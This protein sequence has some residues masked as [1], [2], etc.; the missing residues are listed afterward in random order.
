MKMLS[1]DAGDAKNLNQISKEEALE[2]VAEGL[3][4]ICQTSR[5]DFHE[6]KE[7]SDLKQAIR[8]ADLG[9]YDTLKFYID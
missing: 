8:Y 3:A 5:R 6:V 9:V 4:I 2:F 7:I 1:L